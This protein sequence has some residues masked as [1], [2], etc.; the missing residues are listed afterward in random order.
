MSSV[1][2]PRTL[3]KGYVQAVERLADARP[4]SSPREQAVI[5]LFEALNW[6]VTLDDRLRFD[7]TLGW[8][9]RE[10]ITGGEIVGGLRL[11]RNRVHHAWAPALSEGLVPTTYGNA[12]YGDSTYGRTWLWV[13]L[14]L[15]ALP[16]GEG[17]ERADD[18]AA[19]ASGLQGAEVGETLTQLRG[20]FDEALSFFAR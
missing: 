1:I 9:W 3:F 17:H 15:N 16:A 19:Y 6:A 5:A 18:Q 14:P 13:W 11:A 12:R 20:V 8:D 2:E 7:S 4:R 10:Q